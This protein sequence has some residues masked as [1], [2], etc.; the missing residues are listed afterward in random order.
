MTATLLVNEIFDTIQG[1]AYY[2]GTPAVFVRLQGC[3]VGCNWCDTKHTW[4]IE[5]I[6]KI[7][8]NLLLLK[9]LDSKH[10]A[11]MSVNEL[12]ETLDKFKARHIVITGGE[13][14]IY[15][16]TPFTSAIINSGRSC[17]IETSGTFLV[18][19][20][21]LTW[22]TVSPKLDMAGNYKVLPEVIGRASEIKHPVGKMADIKKLQK[23]IIPF[24]PKHIDVWLQPLSQSEKAT[25][26]CIEQATLHNYKI[27]IQT[28][29]FIGVR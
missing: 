28:H 29:K 8:S 26:L 23:E 27:S 6:Y 10:Y 16:L 11:E 1:E 24:T 22:V 25:T 5:S 15:D 18:K 21:H 12:M 4:E 14:C 7:D 13:P 2:T 20:H 3:P 19:A 17:Q 9:N